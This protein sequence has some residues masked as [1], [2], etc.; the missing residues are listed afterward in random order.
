MSTAILN[1]NPGLINPGRKKTKDDIVSSD[2]YGIH[3]F[4]DIVAFESGSR[5][6]IRRER[7]KADLSKTKQARKVLWQMVTC[8]H[9]K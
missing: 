4:D 3:E 5:L 6:I 9:S 1:G 7:I 2:L 8:A